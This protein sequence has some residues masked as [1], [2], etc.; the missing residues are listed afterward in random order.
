MAR[1]AYSDY[2]QVFPF[3]LFDVAPI[4][5]ISV[6]IFNPLSGFATVTAPGMSFE[7]VDVSEANW[8]FRKKV[9]KKADI[10]PITLTKGVTFYDSDFWRWAIAAITGDPAGFQIRSLFNTLSIGGPTPRRNLI[11]IQFFARNPLS[12]SAGGALAAVNAGLVTAGLG[13]RGAITL[14]AATAV[15]ASGFGPFEFTPRLPAKAWILHDCIPTRFKTGSDF[16]ARS[17]EVSIAEI[18]F[19]PEMIEELSLAS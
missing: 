19:Q 3:W 10:D 4:E 17:G 7:T 2:L 16:D 8:L 14:A 9:I 15:G 12:V 1:S 6:P 18:E 11:L 13:V 5:G